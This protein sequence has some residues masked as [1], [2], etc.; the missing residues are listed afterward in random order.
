MLNRKNEPKLKLDISLPHI[1]PKEYKLQNGNIVYYMDETKEKVITMSLNFPAGIIDEK[2]RLVSSFLQ[3]M[4]LEGGTK[5]YSAKEFAKQTNFYAVQISVSSVRDWLSIDIYIL[6]SKFKK[7]LEFLEE[8]IFN[9]VF[10]EKELEKIK[11]E[12]LANYKKSLASPNWTAG[13]LYAQAMYGDNHA[14]GYFQTEEDYKKIE[15][16]DLVDFHKAQILNAKPQ[17]T[18][19][20]QISKQN[21]DAFDKAFG[22]KFSI[23]NKFTKPSIMKTASIHEKLILKERKEAVQS[24]IVVFKLLDI[25]YTHPDYYKFLITNFLFGGGFFNARLMQKI[26]EEKG[27]TYGIYSNTYANVFSNEIAIK[28][29]VDIKYTNDTLKE[30][31]NEMNLL[32]TKAVTRQL[33]NAAKIVLKSRIAQD[34]DGKYKQ[35]DTFS[36]YHLVG[37]DANEVYISYLNEIDAFTPS[38]VQKIAKKYFNYKDFACVV[39]GK[40]ISDS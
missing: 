19:V 4:L 11:K 2:K 27:Y 6:N 36:Y 40:I 39:V 3:T 28:T 15:Q 14:Y 34:L 7:A 21:L 12:K 24:S 8:I 23:K 37:R 38:D 20:G 31:K 22:T 33:L 16:K 35:I 26:R 18:M 13:K 5:K 30:I 32:Q 1:K 10:D 29:D 17:I 25:D 9:P